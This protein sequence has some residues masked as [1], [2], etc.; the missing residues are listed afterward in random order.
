MS[1]EEL[2]IKM[3]SWRDTSS[4]EGRGWNIISSVNDATA[5]LP[6]VDANGKSDCPVAESRYAARDIMLEDVRKV[7]GELQVEISRARTDLQSLQNNRGTVAQG[8]G[9]LHGEKAREYFETAGVKLQKRIQRVKDR[10]QLLE[11]LI[12]AAY[13]ALQKAADTPFPGREPHLNAE[14]SGAAAAGV[15]AS[16]S[17]PEQAMERE[18][19]PLL[20]L[21]LGST[22]S[23]SPSGGKGGF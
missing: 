17:S 5:T 23:A 22:G 3:G 14:P 8:Q 11:W 2:I 4:V 12:E 7:I 13:E 18:V 6:I 9:E 20:E 10:I 15:P 16:R 21:D 1:R 19:P